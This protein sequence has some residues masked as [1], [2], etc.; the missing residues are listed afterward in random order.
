[1]IRRRTLVTGGVIALAAGLV[2]TTGL[3]WPRQ[4]VTVS[5]TAPT[6]TAEVTRGT[7]RDTKTMTGTLA[8][9]ELSTLR[10]SL[11][12]RSA[13]VTAIAPVG[14]TVERGQPLYALDGEPT[15]L[16]YGSVPQHRTLRF[17][18]GA[19][20]PA[21]IELEHAEAARGAAALTLQLEQQR[22]TDAQTRL[23][24]TG[25][26]LND[27]LS[28]DPA[29]AEFIQLAGAVRAAAA[30]R[31]RV[32]KL[33]AAQLTPSVEI[34]AA[35]AELAAARATFDAAV[36]ALRNELATAKL[37]AI[38]ARVAVAAAEVKL[39]EL[40]TARDALAARAADNADI[41]QIG[42]NLA[43]LGYA[44]SLPNQVRAWQRDAG[45]PVTGIIGPNQLVVAPG[46]AHIASHAVSIG[47][48]LVASSQDGGAILDYS[49]TDKLVTV[50]LAVSDQGLAAVGRAVTITLPDSS[51]VEGTIA[52]V[53]SVVTQGTI[54]VT[55][56]IADQTVLGE[57]EVAAV[58]VEFVSSSREDVL[59]VPIAALL[60]LPEGGFAVEVVDGARS[61]VVPIVTGLFAA[62]RVEIS[63]AGIAEGARVGVPG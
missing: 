3:L 8:Y 6:T 32:G 55:I 50:A 31:E 43:T 49:R 34:A 44:G 59:S 63:G 10:P 57:F 4:P 7:L 22:L 36:R 21:W 48:T 35:D 11:A 42:D 61:S 23:G 1:M 17:D 18:P 25:T 12:G 58:D 33:S 20:S 27:A 19:T 62:G 37:D 41:T 60:A 56:A 5:Q 28:P 39:D 51:E 16:F 45:L 15:L 40:A 54:E 13:M 47:E 24:V 46:P 38:T 26:R 9:G 2:V 53:G 52:E 29:T 14:S 30:R